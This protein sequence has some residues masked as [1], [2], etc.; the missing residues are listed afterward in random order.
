MLGG[1]G[2]R[3]L[4]DFISRCAV[5]LTGGGASVQDLSVLSGPQPTSKPTKHDAMTAD[6]ANLRIF[7]S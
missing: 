1:A 4:V 6:V 3:I 5:G 2:G 7:I